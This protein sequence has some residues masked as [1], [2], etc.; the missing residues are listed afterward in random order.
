MYPA[1]R[2]WHDL[3][4]PRDQAHHVRGAGLIDLRGVAA[5]GAALLSRPVSRR[6]GSTP[7]ARAASP[8]RDLASR[9]QRL[10]LLGPEISLGEAQ[11]AVSDDDGRTPATRHRV[12]KALRDAADRLDKRKGD[13]ADKHKATQSQRRR[14]QRRDVDPLLP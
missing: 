14:C 4:S 1:P 9:L 12:A 10:R 3:R 13:E 2:R 11:M 5:A 7:A 8:R 6:C